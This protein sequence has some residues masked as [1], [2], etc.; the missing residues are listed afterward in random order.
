[1]TPS[2]TPVRR[3]Q[4][5]QRRGPWVPD[6]TVADGHRTVLVDATLPRRRA[7]HRHPGR[8]GHAPP[9]ARATCDETKQGGAGVLTNPVNGSVRLIN[10]DALQPAIGY[11]VAN[12]FI[13]A[14]EMTPPQPGGFVQVLLGLSDRVARTQGVAMQWFRLGGS[15]S[16]GSW[17]SS[18]WICGISRTAQERAAGAAEAAAER[19]RTP[20]VQRAG[21]PAPTM[22]VPRIACMDP[23]IALIVS[24]SSL[25]PTAR[26]LVAEGA[27]GGAGWPVCE[28]ALADV[29]AAL[30]ADTGHRAHRGPGGPGDRGVR[31]P[32]RPGHVRPPGRGPGQCRRAACGTAL[33]TP[34]SDW[35]AGFD[36]VF[37]AP[38][39]GLTRAV[40]GHGKAIAIAWAPSTSVKAPIGGLAVSNW[41]AAR[42]GDAGQAAGRHD[43]TGTRVVE[44]LAE[45]DL[46]KH[47]DS[48]SSDPAAARTAREQGIPLRRY[49]RP[50][51]FGAVAAFLL[52]PAASYVTGSVGGRGRAAPYPRP[53][54]G[55]A[56]YIRRRQE[57]S[58]L[59]RCPSLGPTGFAI[60]EATSPLPSATLLRHRRSRGTRT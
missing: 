17:C 59:L 30:G 10:S 6:S 43:R 51:E 48:L 38:P 8:R 7:G 14:I 24:S 15:A 26:Q 33:G 39:S 9:A 23:G 28:E 29:V 32:T 27:K 13:S 58:I 42:P 60:I 35:V 53:V 41:A 54:T 50:E 40:V 19:Q 20:A 46:V 52:S 22:A 11:P 5:Q 36:A 31:L 55:T 37:L 1:M 34:D 47:L 4:P 44:I 2:A 21:A 45:T 25:L 56:S 12:G 16:S 18:D 3:P 57:P 49:G